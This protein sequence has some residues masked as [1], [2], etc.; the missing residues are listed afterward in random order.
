MDRKKCIKC[1]NIKDI[2]KFYLRSDTKKYRKECKICSKEFHSSIYI[3]NI[4]KYKKHNKNYYISNKDK[5]LKQQKEWYKENKELIAQR[6]LEYQRNNPEGHCKRNKI[7]RDRYPKRRL[8]LTRKRQLEKLQ[9]TPVGANLDIIKIFYENCQQGY[10]VDH[11]IPLK[12][13]TVSGLHIRSNLQYL[14]P[15]DNLKKRNKFD[16]TLENIGWKNG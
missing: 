3:K 15:E 10:E 11:I 2:I 13:K 1:N 9:R 5:V 12:G 4:N 8:Y 6:R 16:F 14:L 7:Y